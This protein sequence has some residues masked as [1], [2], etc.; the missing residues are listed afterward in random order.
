MPEI[1]RWGVIDPLGNLDVQID[2]SPYQFSWNNPVKL[3]NSDGKCPCWVLVLPLV[4]EALIAAGVLTAGRTYVVVNFDD[5]VPSD[6]MR[7]HTAPPEMTD[8]RIGDPKKPPMLP[9]SKLWKAAAV[10][11]SIAM[12]IKSL[13]APSEEAKRI[14][15]AL[16]SLT[17]EDLVGLS[18]EQLELLAQIIANPQDFSPHP[19]WFG[20]NQDLVGTATVYDI[21]KEIY[22]SKKQIGNYTENDFVEETT[23]KKAKE[24]LEKPFSQIASGTYEWDGS[25]WVSTKV[26]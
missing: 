3:L 10:A 9:P 13:E 16:R 23:G 25:N 21:M 14:A 22:A 12:L 1:G 7:Y 17:A 19:V 6:R 5:F 4:Y 18:E 26:N 11:A 2:K 15:N 8:L 20:L 24:V